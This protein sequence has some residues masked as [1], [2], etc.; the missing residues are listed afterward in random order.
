MLHT[1]Y[2]QPLKQ[3]KYKDSWATFVGENIREQNSS[4]PV[5]VNWVLFAISFLLLV[6]GRKK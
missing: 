2:A 5:G 1:I 4:R 6:I 3:C